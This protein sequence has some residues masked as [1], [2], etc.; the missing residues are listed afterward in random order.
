[1]CTEHN[2]QQR[3]NNNNRVIGYN[4]E[5]LKGKGFKPL[6]GFYRHNTAQYGLRKSL[7]YIGDDNGIPDSDCN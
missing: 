7:E 2:G 6:S 4:A 5:L 3:Y 1:M